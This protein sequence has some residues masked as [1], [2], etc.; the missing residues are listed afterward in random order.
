MLVST[1]DVGP[2]D[3]SP[4]ANGA[5]EPSHTEQVSAPA[6]SAELLIGR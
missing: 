5:L 2:V 6:T 3:A 4:V 1:Q